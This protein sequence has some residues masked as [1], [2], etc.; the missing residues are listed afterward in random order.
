MLREQPRT[1]IGRFIARRSSRSGLVWGTIFGSYVALS[2]SGY[3]SAYPTAVSRAKF[4]NALSTNSGLAALLGDA[5]RLD[6]VAGFTAWRCTGVLTVV[7]AIWGLLTATRWLRGEEDAG[8]WELL[9][10]GLTTRRGAATQALAGLSIALVGLWSV[11]ASV[12]VSDGWTSQVRFSATSSLFLSTALVAGAAMFLAVGALVS[13]LCANRRQ[14]NIVGAVVLGGAYL[15]RM[16]A[17]SGA[18]VGWLRWATP[19]GW[20]ENLRP[21]T[22]SRLLPWLP[23][24]VLTVATSVAACDLAG[25]RDLAA[26]ALPAPDAPR[27]HL[28]LLGS[29]IGLTVRLVA[30]V[31]V[32]WIV[33][34]AACGLVFGLVAQS[35]ADA[36]SG[37]ATVERALARLGGHH[38]G[39]GAYLGLTLLFA[40]AL[41]AFA[42]AGQIAAVRNEEADGYVDHLLVRAASRGRWLGGRLAVAAGVV[43]VASVVAGLA[44]WVGAASQHSGVGVVLLF[45]AGV[46]I[47]PVALFVLGVGALAFGLSPRL[48]APATYGIVGWSFLI[49]I[50]GSTVKLNRWILDTCVLHHIAPVPA[51]DPN[52][53]S[54]LGLTALGAL[55]AIGGLAAFNRRDV[56][57]A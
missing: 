45:E 57:G 28:G 36:A 41:V 56:V 20:V 5:R 47:A 27:S 44:G 54:A 22:G 43:V 21:L 8:R 39:A 29:P 31:G 17:D 14:A 15:I 33:G 19:L 3:A 2:A 10:T 24:V 7:G 35:A 1:V 52:W 49:E 40:A 11:L 48:A 53:G 4:A 37:S 46:N 42:A 34:L 12:V 51:A 9:L 55:A 6:T 25:R 18:G 32:A 23:I 13:E 50:V 38:G 16:V 30:G 26:S